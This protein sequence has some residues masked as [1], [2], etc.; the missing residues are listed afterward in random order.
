MRALRA[1]TIAVLGLGLIAAAC[2]GG[3]SS[4]SPAQAKAKITA[5]W[6]KFFDPSVPVDQKQDIVQNYAALKPTLQQQTTNPQAQGIKA[7][8]ADVTLSGDKAATVRYDIVNAKDGTPLLPNASG[9][10]VKEGDNWKVSEQTFCQLV[11]LADQN[12]KC[13]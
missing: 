7:K 9:S 10:A 11:K 6:E 1:F 3:G 5:A 2:G 12:A 8:V 13:P 4:E